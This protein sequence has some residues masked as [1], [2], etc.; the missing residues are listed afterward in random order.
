MTAGEVRSQ[1]KANPPFGELRLPF[2]SLEVHM[3]AFYGYETEAE[4]RAEQREYSHKRDFNVREGNRKC[5]SC[6][7]E[8]EG[9][10]ELVKDG[11]ILR[12]PL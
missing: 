5:K 9:S 12:Q 10:K 2:F 8:K 4:E 6:R 11:I 3:I 1:S 7:D